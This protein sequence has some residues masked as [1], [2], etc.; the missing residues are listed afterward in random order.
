MRRER[1]SEPLHLLNGLKVSRALPKVDCLL[2]RDEQCA[3]KLADRQ[4]CR[5]LS[6]IRR[7]L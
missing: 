5:E 3:S 1:G 7:S 6:V 4:T 2:I